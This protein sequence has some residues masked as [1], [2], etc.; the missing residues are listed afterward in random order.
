MDKAADSS[1]SSSSKEEGTRAVYIVE[2]ER[3]RMVEGVVNVVWAAKWRT[4]STECEA[5]R[6]RRK[7][8]SHTSPWM[9]VKLGHERE[10]PGFS[11]LEQ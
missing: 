10:K 9:K 4:A 7:G 8:R 3:K 2:D 1:G 5:K 6:E 11:R